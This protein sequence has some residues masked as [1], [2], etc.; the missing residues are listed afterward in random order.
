MKGAIAP[1]NF[2]AIFKHFLAD[3]LRE[4]PQSKNAATLPV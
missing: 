4:D 3:I 2:P 1:F